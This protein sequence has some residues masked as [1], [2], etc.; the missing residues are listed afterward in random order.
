MNATYSPKTNLW[1]QLL[2]LMLALPLGMIALSIITTL[3]IACLVLILT[4]FGMMLAPSWSVQLFKWKFE[5]AADAWFLPI[6]GMLLGWG[7]VYIIKKMGQVST[8]FSSL[9]L[10]RSH[11]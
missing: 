9:L 3:I 11:N 7:L 10:S 6:C 2:Y 5:S 8:Q 4:P 1:N